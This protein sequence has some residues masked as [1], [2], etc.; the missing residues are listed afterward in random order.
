MIAWVTA[1]AWM[2]SS[3]IKQKGKSQNGVTR[4]RTPLIFPKNEYFWPPDTHT[5]VCLSGRE[6]CLL[7]GKYGVLCFLVT[8]VLR[9]ALLPY[10]RRSDIWLREN[11]KLFKSHSVFKKK[12]W[13]RISADISIHFKVIYKNINLEISLI[14][15]VGWAWKFHCSGI[16]MELIFL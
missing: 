10:Y 1:D 15:K 6:K 14:R 5:C 7:F 4:K 9:L 3:L 8:A 16:F 2:K 12:I 13:A 11:I